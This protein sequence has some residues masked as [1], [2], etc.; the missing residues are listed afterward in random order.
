MNK[1]TKF[2]NNVQLTFLREENYLMCKISY[3]KKNMSNK[4]KFF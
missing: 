1:V 3:V 2:E 4:Y